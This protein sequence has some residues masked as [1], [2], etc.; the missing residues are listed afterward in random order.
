[1]SGAAIL[2]ELVQML[3]LERIEENLFRG[4]S[5]DPGWGQVFGGHVLGQALSAAAQ[6]VAAERPVHSMHAYFL[7]PGD[8][9]RPILYDVDRIRDGG[10]FTT[11]R[12]VAIQNGKAI[13]NLAVSFQTIED[14]FTHQ[15][16]MP[17][18]PPPESL[19][20]EQELAEAHADRLPPY[21]VKRAMA[22]RPFE[23]RPVDPEAALDGAPRPPRRM[24]W[25]KT[26]G[27]LP[28]ND[29]LHRYLLAYASD[30]MFV[31]TSLLPHGV[32][33]LTPGMQIASL[34]HVMYFHQP[35][36]VDDWLLHVV[37]SPAASGGRGLVRG[38]IFSRDGKL[39]ASTAQ[40]GLIR[41]KS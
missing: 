18:A 6:R 27:A 12:V 35:L 1:M 8:V 11:R 15:D 36:R 31:T 40:E 34:D 17:A 30:F 26:I 4:Q 38:Q 25:L 20:N 13:F 9:S 23:I 5:H 7:R 28:D 41:R 19:K 3:A 16:A 24:M 21:F 22:V 33:W 37:E 14:G 2:D 10:S 39:V 32:T 29:A